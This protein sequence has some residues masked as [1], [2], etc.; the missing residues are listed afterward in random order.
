MATGESLSTYA[1][2]VLMLIHMTVGASGFIA[3]VLT[4]L[5][6][7]GSRRSWPLRAIGWLTLLLLFAA[8]GAG[9]VVV[10]CIAFSLW[11]VILVNGGERLAG[12]W[13]GAFRS[14]PRASGVRRRKMRGNTA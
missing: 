11:M 4:V 13:G 5:W 14:L 8:T 7:L 2:I 1:S 9:E 10:F 3:L 12:W 6:S